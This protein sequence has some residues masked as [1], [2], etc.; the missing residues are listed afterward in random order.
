[1]RRHCSK[2]ETHL[3]NIDF[4]G[5]MILMMLVSG[6][7][8]SMACLQPSSSCLLSGQHPNGRNLSMT[9]PTDKVVSVDTQK[10]TKGETSHNILLM[11]AK[12]FTSW[13]LVLDFIPSHHIWQ[14]LSTIP[15]W[16]RN[17]PDVWKHHAN[18]TSIY[19]SPDLN[20][21]NSWPHPFCRW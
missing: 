14:L 5:L 15:G 13:G 18:I 17:S 20:K 11:P 21:L 4:H 19:R 6:R 10:E 1:M 16:L 12:E 7:V 3:P 9:T 8:I 2:K